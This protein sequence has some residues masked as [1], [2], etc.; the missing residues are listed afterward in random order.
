VTVWADDATTADALST[1]LLVLG[2]ADAHQVLAREPGAG[3]LFITDTQAAD[4]RQPV[5]VGQPPLQWTPLQTQ[6]RGG[7]T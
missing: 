6:R 1:A 7:S 3:A 5:L 4:A 2:P